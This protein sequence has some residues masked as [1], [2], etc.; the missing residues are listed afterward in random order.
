MRNRTAAAMTAVAAL[1]FAAP[2]AAHVTLDPGE[3]PADGYA[4]L[5]VQVPHG[6]EGSPTKAL[7]V[8]IPKSVPSVTPQVHPGWEVATKE[9]PKDPVELHG[10]QVTRGVSEVIWTAGDAG[11][12]PDGRLDVFGMSVKLPA[13][14]A[15]DAVYFPTVQECVKGKTGWI[16]IPAAGESEDDLE[17]PAPAVVLTAAEDGHGLSDSGGGDQTAVVA[18]DGDDG[19]S[20]GL[21]IAAL[22][23]GGLGL[24]TGLAALIGGRRRT[25]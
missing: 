18:S 9:G 3:A 14:K 16:Q 13:G 6:C 7:R 22:V 2:A 24:L 11:P 5:D 17:S 25:A 1:A 12:L 4:T 19:P 23:L 15:G 20:M 21:V 8:Q 10:E